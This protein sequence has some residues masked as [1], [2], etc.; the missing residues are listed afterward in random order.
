VRARLKLEPGPPLADA[1]MDLGVAQ[2]PVRI[3]PAPFV[4]KRVGNGIGKLE[5]T[6]VL[7]LSLLK[8]GRFAAASGIPSA[9]Y[10]SSV[11]ALSIAA[12][13]SLQT[14]AFHAVWRSGARSAQELVF[15]LFVPWRGSPSAV[16]TVQPIQFLRDAVKRGVL[17]VPTLARLLTVRTPT[18]PVH[19]FVAACLRGDITMSL[20]ATIMEF[21]GGMRM[22]WLSESWYLVR[23]A[24]LGSHT[25]KS[26]A[27]VALRRPGIAAALSNGIDRGLTLR[28]ENSS[29][30]ES[31]K[32]AL[33]V[34]LAGGVIVQKLAARWVAGGDRCPHCKLAVED[35]SHL[36]WACPRWEKLRHITLGSHSKAELLRLFGAASLVSGIIPNDR[37]LVDAQAAAEAC[38]S[39]PAVVHLPGRVWT[40]GSCLHPADSPL[41]RAT[42]GVVGRKPDGFDTLASAI[43]HGRQTI[44]RAELSAIIWVSRCPGDTIAV[45]D[46]K[47]LTF[48]LARCIGDICP[49][50]L[51][52]GKNGDL[53][54]LLLRQV[55]LE[56]VKAHLTAIQAEALGISEEDRLGNDAADSAAS[57]L[58]HTI[59]PAPILVE[60]RARWKEGADALHY[61]LGSIQEAALEA[62]HAPGSAVR[63]RRRAKRARPKPKAKRPAIA[64]PVPPPLAEAAPGAVVHVLRPMI[65]PSVAGVGGTWACNLCNVTATGPTRS[66]RS[67][68]RFATL[69]HAPCTPRGRS[70]FTSSAGSL[71]AG[72]VLVV[73][74]RSRRTVVRR[75][76]VPS[77]RCPWCCSWGTILARYRA[78][79]FSAILRLWRCGRP[80]PP[81]GPPRLALSLARLLLPFAWFGGPTGLSPAGGALHVFYAAVQPLRVRALGWLPVRVPAFPRLP[82]RAS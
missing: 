13:R 50:A 56:W 47:Y 35:L 48:C 43:V 74:W 60:R 34:V 45:I 73:D 10:G 53:W 2:P 41:R 57:T 80:R 79:K 16:C 15:G 81:S 67:Q 38:G 33:R 52:E 69:I 8:R 18:G 61:V 75:L 19:A 21:R 77:A 29:W 40:D 39:W 9:T 37:A 14:A 27:A 30:Q 36:F 62:H 24:I 49:A 31:R 5:R 66:A 44:G 3:A 65:G 58:A 17:D 26:Y 20:D 32:A 28:F 46:A 70:G 59:A 1:F 63:G 25:A 7:S 71:V 76:P 12:L 6:S 64:R 42:W 55:S 82:L 51:L 68:R 22:A 78:G 11:T 72:P 4:R 54:R 23:Q